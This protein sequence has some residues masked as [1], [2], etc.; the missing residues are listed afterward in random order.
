[1]SLSFDINKY[2]GPDFDFSKLD[3]SK[4]NKIQ[5]LTNKILN[6][7]NPAEIKSLEKQ[8]GKLLGSAKKGIS[9]SKAV[10]SLA[11]RR[12]EQAR[13]KYLSR[14]GE[15]FIQHIKPNAQRE[16]TKIVT[17]TGNKILPS[18]TQK[19]TDF[20]T[21]AEKDRATWSRLNQSLEELENVKENDFN[22]LHTK[23]PIIEKNIA[24]CEE[25]LKFIGQNEM[26]GEII[27]LKRKFEDLSQK[28]QAQAASLAPPSTNDLNEL[29]RE[30]RGLRGY[31]PRVQPRVVPTSVPPAQ[32]TPKTPVIPVDQD[33]PNPASKVALDSV[34][35][36]GSNP[37]VNLPRSPISRKWDDEGKEKSGARPEKEPPKVVVEHPKTQLRART[38]VEDKWE[39]RV[40]TA[41]TFQKNPDVL[42]AKLLSH[43]E[44]DLKKLLQDTKQKMKSVKSQEFRQFSGLSEDESRMTSNEL[45]QHLSE[46]KSQGQT[47]KHIDQLETVVNMLDSYAGMIKVI[48]DSIRETATYSSLARK[49][50]VEDILEKDIQEI[51]LPVPSPFHETAP[52]IPPKETERVRSNVAFADAG[53]GIIGGEQEYRLSKEERLEKIEALAELEAGGDV[54]LKAEILKEN[55]ARM[56][57]IRFKGSQ[58]ASSLSNAAKRRES[59]KAKMAAGKEVEL[60]PEMR[61]AIVSFRQGSEKFSERIHELLNGIENLNQEEAVKKL[62]EIKKLLTNMI[63]F[64]GPYKDKLPENFQEMV[65]N[66]KQLKEI[67]DAL[68]AKNRT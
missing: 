24:E 31:Q 9:V 20:S 49:P 7:K 13:E 56:T 52:L 39:K 26:K 46:L 65:S 42:K 16:S 55:M 35:A 63:N 40:N 33:A 11:S 59:I 15:G 64:A 45:K 12:S 21:P 61:E 68:A 27:V 14:R 30:M 58:R 4:K 3:T 8:L 18:H 44:E 67:Y 25:V 2:Q 43:S 6:A 48:N 54:A 41:K 47:G 1:M 50:N 66:I 53:G 37:Q 62:S 17:E 23:L 10:E 19:A 32:P 28:A 36:Q 60:S 34:L 38:D 22:N 51:E 57:K 5:N 29:V